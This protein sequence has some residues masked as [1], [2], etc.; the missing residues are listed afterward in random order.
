MPAQLHLSASKL[1][2]HTQKNSNFTVLSQLEWLAVL[3]DPNGQHHHR[4]GSNFNLSVLSTTN[5]YTPQEVRCKL[6][7]LPVSK[8]FLVLFRSI[9][10]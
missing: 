8:V 3:L 9:F 7:N 1:Y 2:W 4:Y 5:T 6:R 10:C